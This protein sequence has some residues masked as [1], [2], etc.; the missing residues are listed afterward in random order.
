MVINLTSLTWWF[1]N[2]ISERIPG[3]SFGTGAHGRVVYNCT[4]CRE[5][6][7]SRAR[8]S[9]L[10]LYASLV[11]WTFLIYDTFGPAVRWRSYIVR[12]TGTGR[13]VSDCS[14][15]RIWPTR[16]WNAWVYRLVINRFKHRCWNYFLR[17]WTTEIL[18]V[19]YIR[20]ELEMKIMSLRGMW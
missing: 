1:Q 20:P 7:R 14:A 3:I 11:E 16:G 2:A 5:P 19:N 12:S 4:L 15:L 8:I 13:T 6:T 9:T 18:A 17:K 10:F